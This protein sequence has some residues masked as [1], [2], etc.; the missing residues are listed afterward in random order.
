MCIRDRFYRELQ[1]HSHAP[2]MP[3]DE[4]RLRVV[5][6]D[7]L[8]KLLREI[9]ATQDKAAQLS[10]V[11]RVYVWFAKRRKRTTKTLKKELGLLRE[12]EA[13][14]PVKY[15]DLEL[16]KK[17]FDEKKRTIYPEIPPAKD[18][19]ADFSVRV[20]RPPEEA[21]KEAPPVAEAK[22]EVRGG[23]EAEGNYLL[24]RARRA[25][26]QKVERLWFEKK[27]KEV[28]KK[29]EKEEFETIVK[30]W[31]FAKSKFNENLT[32]KCENVNYGNNFG[33]RTA[34]TTARRPIT[35]VTEFKD[36]DYEQ[37]YH[38][39]SSEEEE[40]TE[41]PF[42]ER[43]KHNSE[44]PEIVDFRGTEFKFANGVGLMPPKTAPVNAKRGQAVKK[45]KEL[46]PKVVDVISESD[47]N[48]VEFVR[49]M[50]GGLIGEENDN[51]ESAA[52][53]FASGLK[54]VNS[55]SIYNKDVQRPYTVHDP[56]RLG[57]GVPLTHRGTRD[58]FRVHQLKEMNSMKEHLAKNEIPCSITTLRRAVLLPEDY[59]QF[60]MTSQNFLLPGSRLMVNPFAKK[61]KKK[62][63]AKKKKAKK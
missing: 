43:S 50:Y 18:R 61:K 40:L 56:T 58:Q 13:P 10:C 48:R 49:R 12:Q 34:E 31:G 38:E 21:K 32:R 42:T 59:P 15:L 39:P 16:S 57:R 33:V 44:L 36:P 41:R 30:N 51:M 28:G 35:G 2:D 17:L 4:L 25:E 5:L 47:R 20:V 11:Q 9:I 1:T 27:N 6:Y 60:H 14:K 26:E 62:K 29:R 7:C 23:V 3:E 22:E 37:I 63:K 24:Y 52:N 45:V 54:G 46:I 8:K 55:L 53:I 19:L